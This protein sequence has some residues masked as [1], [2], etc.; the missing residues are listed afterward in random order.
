MGIA[1]SCLW[2]E[3]AWGRSE[4]RG[5][6]GG[7]ACLGQEVGRAEGGTRS[8]PDRGRETHTP[9]GAVRAHPS[10]TTALKEAVVTGGGSGAQQHA[11]ALLVGTAAGDLASSLCAGSQAGGTSQPGSASR[12]REGHLPNHSAPATVSTPEGVPSGSILLLGAQKLPRKREG[13]SPAGTPPGA[14]RAQAPLSDDRRR[15]AGRLQA[16][17]DWLKCLFLHPHFLLLFL[18]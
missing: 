13:G 18:F 9:M 2:I 4:V 7:M 15:E 3:P 14:G 11:Q 16:C 17:L 6:L 8:Q 12:G 5:S 1:G 10:L